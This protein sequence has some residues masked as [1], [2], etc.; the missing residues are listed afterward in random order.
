MA[1]SQ[2]LPRCQWSAQKASP[3]QGLGTR[4]MHARG[5]LGAAV[6]PAGFLR[7]PWSCSFDFR[8]E[9]L[10]RRRGGSTLLYL[11]GSGA[12]NSVVVMSQRPPTF[13]TRGARLPIRPTL[14]NDPTEAGAPGGVHHR[15]GASIPKGHGSHS[16]L[17][18]GQQMLGKGAGSRRPVS[19][20]ED[21][22]PAVVG[23]LTSSVPPGDR[24]SPESQGQATQ[25]EGRL[26]LGEQ[27]QCS[28]T[29]RD[30]W[31]PW[32]D[33]QAPSSLE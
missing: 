20:A 11:A 12:A 9:G 4:W 16:R 25:T 28:V 26:Q 18:P 30:T 7:A 19:R 1:D 33:H 2:L 22:E 27:G 10:Q 21:A 3:R 31:A 17:G 24:N 6:V 32:Q 13:K 5:H 8:T 14:G 15:R 29:S 23:I